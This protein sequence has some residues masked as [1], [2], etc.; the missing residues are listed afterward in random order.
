MRTE[1]AMSNH[2]WTLENLD[3]YLAGG[4]T[5]DERKGVEEHSAFCAECAQT[6]AESR[7]LEQT[8]D[9]VFAKDRPDA[10]LEERT[11]AKLRKARM[12]RATSLRFVAAAA[13][14]LVLGLLGA[15][16]Q[17]IAFSDRP[18]S[19]FEG[20]TLSRNNIKE[21]LDAGKRIKAAKG[22]QAA[23][24]RMLDDTSSMGFLDPTNADTTV[25]PDDKNEQMPAEKLPALGGYAGGQGGAIDG[26]RGLALSKAVDSRSG[27][28]KK[29]EMPAGGENKDILAKVN[30]TRVGSLMLGTGMN[31]DNGVVGNIHLGGFSLPAIKEKLSTEYF[32]P[33]E[34]AKDEPSK[35]GP[36]KTP[37]P[38]PSEPALQSKL[39]RKRPDDGEFVKDKTKTDPPAPEPLDRKIIRTGGME[40]EI[41][42]F[43]NAVDGVGKLILAVKGGFIATV[44]SEK[45]PNGKVRGSVVVRMPPEHL[46]KFILDLR[47]ELAKTGELRSQRIGSQDVTKQYTDIAS[48]LRAAR[49]VEGRLIE[50]IKTGKGEVKD[51]IAAERELGTWRTKIE[52]MEGEIRY[53]NNQ[54]SLSTLTI[55]LAEKEILAPSALIVTDHIKM[56]VEVEEVAKAHQAAL[57]AVADLQGR[58]TKSELKQ[59]KAGQLEAILH[60]EIPPAKKEA[61]RDMLKTLGIV[62]EHEETQRQQ[63]EGG[64]GKVQ[65]IKPRVNDVQFE[66]ALNNIVNIPPRHSVSL[67]IATTDVPGNFAK[68]QEAILR[69]AKGQVR[70]GKIDEQDKQNVTAIIDFNVPIDQKPAIDKLIAAVGP[71]LT[72]SA[73]Q[74]PVTELATD[75]KYGYVVTLRSVANIA[76]RESITLKI[77]VK[78]VDQRVADLKEMVRAGKGRVADVNVARQ[79]NGQVVAVLIFDVPLAVEDLLVRQIKETGNLLSQQTT[80]NPN[81]PENELATAQIVVTL[82]GVFAGKQPREK[83]EMQI[84]VGDVDKKA[85]EL[86]DLVRASKGRVAGDNVER[87]PNG[88]V[89][90]VLL[91]EVPLSAREALVQQFKGSEHVV[92]YKTG[93]N[94]NVPDNDLATAQI[95]VTL[96]NAPILPS[97]QSYVEKSLYLSY[98]VFAYCMLAIVVGLSAA[99]PIGGVMFVS[100]WLIRKLWPAERITTVV[101]VKPQTKE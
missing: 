80:R 81:V 51:L 26:I 59:Y 65:A 70:V 85:K 19:D 83:V 38:P 71:V 92:S 50:I 10:G 31:S 30:E 56:R 5:P 12:T 90:A 32:K 1:M 34:Q 73:G 11:I 53:Y 76:P 16:M 96:T 18:V 28:T 52:K 24:G 20:R 9:E 66:V 48:E 79:E 7:K 13:A 37:P 40:F 54:V 97:D 91:F 6:L 58:V 49:V 69:I 88:H 57:K 64:T 3:A 45:L 15:A 95:L 47:R 78:D 25:L 93:R 35:T 33:S 94:A 84:D 60:A 44:N 42:S 21:S 98:T 77:E 23:K 61:F 86:K 2:D 22:I 29:D 43:D 75:R 46:D 82:N 4:L 68:L 62:S 55:T 27:A 87:Q 63:A 72:R 41:D 14:V 100:Y 8:M 17:A 101:S 99:V 67:L 39:T 89:T 36:A 74:T